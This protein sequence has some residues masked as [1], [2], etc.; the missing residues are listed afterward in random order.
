MLSII[1]CTLNEEHYLPM[2][3]DTLNQQEGTVFEV[4]VMDA[5]SDDDTAGVVR[6]YQTRANYPLRFFQLQRPGLSTQ[7]NI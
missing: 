2:L 5:N 1:I 3:L 4:V 7:R 6:N